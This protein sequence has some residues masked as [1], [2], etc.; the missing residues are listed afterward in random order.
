MHLGILAAQ[1]RPLRRVQESSVIRP[2]GR[3][4]VTARPARCL[5]TRTC[6][7]SKA[8]AGRRPARRSDR[9]RAARRRALDPARRVLHIFSIWGTGTTD[10]SKTR[11]AAD[12]GMTYGS[13][14]RQ[15]TPK[16]TSGI[17]PLKFTAVP[18]QDGPREPRLRNIHAYMCARSR[19]QDMRTLTSC[20]RCSVLY[21]PHS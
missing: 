2:A 4:P 10:T 14:D 19:A 17:L 20:T 13:I 18:V 21:Y 12:D 7:I 15:S 6:C 9:T 1:R 5:R 11:A 8:P 3:H 16:D